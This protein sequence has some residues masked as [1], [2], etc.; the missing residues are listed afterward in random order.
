ML[1]T[2]GGRRGEVNSKNFSN[3]QK[4]FRDTLFFP[5][6]TKFSGH[7]IIFPKNNKFFR[8]RHTKGHW[9]KKCN[10]NDIF[11]GGKGHFA[12]GEVYF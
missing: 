12:P 10:L 1:A 9:A 4:N 7:I 2:E 8:S 11:H 6:I 3:M 5:K